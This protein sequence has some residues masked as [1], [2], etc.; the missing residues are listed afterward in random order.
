MRGDRVTPTERAKRS[1]SLYYG[2]TKRRELCDRAALLES[3]NEELK[4]RVSDLECL[5]RDMFYM[6]SRDYPEPV[7]VKWADRLEEIGVEP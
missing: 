7:V 4:E 1:D 6:V 2:N 3:D 5:V